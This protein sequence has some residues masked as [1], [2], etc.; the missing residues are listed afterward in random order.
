M[1]KVT[2]P[3]PEAGHKV[4][5]LMPAPGKCPAVDRANDSSADYQ[6]VRRVNPSDIQFFLE[7]ADRIAGSPNATHCAISASAQMYHGIGS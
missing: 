7:T 3:I 6:H 2:Q 1:A 5:G 4:H